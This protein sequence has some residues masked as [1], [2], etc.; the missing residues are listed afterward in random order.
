VACSAQQI[1]GDDA[2]AQAEVSEN[3]VG[4]AAGSGILCQREAE[5]ARCGGVESP[6]DSKQG[7]NFAFAKLPVS[8]R[9]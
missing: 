2:G 3:L 1:F 8:V 4:E 5:L 9:V 6:F 7:S